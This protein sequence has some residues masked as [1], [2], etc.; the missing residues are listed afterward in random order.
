[1]GEARL[2]RHCYNNLVKWDDDGWLPM[3]AISDQYSFI[4]LIGNIREALCIDG[5]IFVLLISEVYNIVTN[6]NNVTVV[7][8]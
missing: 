7:I 5:E 4:T 3:F 6:V 2:H 8:Y 1:V